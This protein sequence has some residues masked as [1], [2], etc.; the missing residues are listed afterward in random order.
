ML[1]LLLKVLAL[2]IASTASP[3]IFGVTLSLLA[4][5]NHGLPRAMAVLCGGILSVLLLLAA[6][7]VIGTS[8]PGY[9][10]ELRAEAKTID[11][12][13][14]VIFL[15]FAFFSFF[16]KDRAR[17]AAPGK[18]GLMKWLAIGFVMNI[19]NLDAVLLMLT[20]VKE[21]VQSAVII[22]EKA[23]LVALAALFFLL[24]SLLPLAVYAAR[25]GRAA[26]MLEPVGVFMV[27]YGR[28][29]ACAVFLG[30]GIYLALRGLA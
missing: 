12:A 30:F 23:V 26:R 29:L 13:L 19:T 18:A 6:G 20:S 25:P 5:K 3:V 24:P 7:A 10:S 28:Y 17:S 2:G 9:A 15:L 14:A 27:R 11:L 21:A 4:G 22:P 1:D 16:H 8:L